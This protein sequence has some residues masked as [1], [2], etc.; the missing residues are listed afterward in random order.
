MDMFS[1]TEISAKSAALM[2]TMDN[3]NRK[4]GK[5]SIKLASEG[6]RRPWKMRQDNKS[7][8]YTTNWDDIPVIS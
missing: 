7:P 4:M 3:I 5:E 2:Q 8:T 1:R 6:F